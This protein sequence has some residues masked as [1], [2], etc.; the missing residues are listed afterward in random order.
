LAQP[1]AKN[2][3]TLD[4]VDVFT[5]AQPGSL[6]CLTA[7]AFMVFGSFFGGLPAS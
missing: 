5:G 6:S 7:A 1:L 2:A 3:K 4:S